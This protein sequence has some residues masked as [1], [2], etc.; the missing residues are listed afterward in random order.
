MRIFGSNA[1]RAAV[2]SAALLLSACLLYPSMQDRMEREAAAVA[3]I[4]RAYCGETT[5]TKLRLAFREETNR[6][7]FPDKI[8]VTCAHRTTT[9]QESP[10]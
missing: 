3:G 5:S 8:E 10:P 7:L 1:S 2:T 6:Q 4:I 9:E